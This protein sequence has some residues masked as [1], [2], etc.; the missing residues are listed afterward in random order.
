MTGQFRSNSVTPL[1]TWHLAQEFATRPLLNEEFIVEDAP[2]ERIIAVV[3]EPHFIMDC[4]FDYRCAR[5]MPVFGVPGLIDH[6]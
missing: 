3:T 1:D 2:V 4:A 5:A 6:F